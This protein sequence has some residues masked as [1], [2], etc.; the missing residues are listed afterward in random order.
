[1]VVD[2]NKASTADGRV[3]GD[4]HDLPDV[5][6]SPNDLSKAQAGQQIAKDLLLIGSFSFVFLPLI[7]WITGPAVSTDQSV[8]RS[9][10][11]MA[12]ALVAVIAQLH[13]CRSVFRK[14]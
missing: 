6:S 8:A 5:A 2:R 14:T 11:W 10:V 7:V 9:I 4:V 1:M 3:D 13:F 12:A